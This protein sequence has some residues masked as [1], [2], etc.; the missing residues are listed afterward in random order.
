MPISPTLDPRQLTLLQEWLPGYA[1]VRDHSW[2]LV[3]TTVWEVAC[4]GERYVVKAAGPDDHHLARELRAHREWIAPWVRAG[5]A[6][7][8]VYADP[9]AKIIV[10][11]YLEGELMLG[12]AAARD[13]EVYRQAGA[14]LAQLHGQCAMVD[15]AFEEEANAGL[16]AWLDKEHRIDPGTVARLRAEVA[17]WPTPPAVVVPTHGDWQPR[18]WLVA[19]AKTATRAGVEVRVI[20]FGRAAMRPAMSDLARLSRKEFRELPALEAPFFD[21]YGPDPREPEAW[22]RHQLREAAGTAVWAYLHGDP[23]FEAEGHRH[24]AELI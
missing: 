24:L 13:P 5:R 22:R 16:L 23:D 17:G 8:L 12:H 21:G 10:T 3:D 9:A 14:L 19:P 18:N 11:R 1:V 20:D 2:G 7:E 6:P 15:A 4:A